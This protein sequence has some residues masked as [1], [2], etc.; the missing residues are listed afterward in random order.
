MP[1]CRGRRPHLHD[2]D[3]NGCDEDMHV[4]AILLGASNLWFSF[5]M[6]SIALPTT[7]DKLDALVKEQ[8]GILERVGS[9]D[10][11]TTLEK[12]GVLKHFSE[13]SVSELWDAI[14]RK[15]HADKAPQDE[16]PNLL[17]PEWK[18]F[19]NPAPQYQTTDFRLRTVSPPEK[20]KSLISQI[21]LVE[22]MRE[23]RALVGFTRIDS[24]GESAETEEEDIQT[25]APISRKKPTW[26]PAIEVHGEGVFIQ[27]NEQAIQK[28]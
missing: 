13:F 22:R 12:F 6:N 23:V 17:L 9:L 7:S 25:I 5:V 20:Y 10:E 19:T 18:V 15:R 27:F 14:V 4:R 8:W 2:Y 11:L 26:L 21:I 1:L 16:R 28:W 3:P 24:P